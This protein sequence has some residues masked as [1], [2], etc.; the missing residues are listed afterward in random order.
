MTPII[1]ASLT[2]H[3]NRSA[4]VSENTWR[5][6]S[7]RMPVKSA[8]SHVR[9]HLIPVVST[10]VHYLLCARPYA[11][12]IVHVIYLC[13][14]FLIVVK[15]QNNNFT[16]LTIRKL[17]SSVVLCILTP[18][19]RTPFILQNWNPVPD[20]HHFPIPSSPNPHPGNHHSTFCLCEFDN[21]VYLMS[22]ELYHICPFV[23]G[24]FHLA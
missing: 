20:N 1:C 10:L 19:S 15:I 5:S 6:F 12:L 16:I 2:H 13:F 17:Y 4:S 14:K 11:Q 22:V 3:S 24:I 8:L 23:I 7:D 21:S 9:R 18:V